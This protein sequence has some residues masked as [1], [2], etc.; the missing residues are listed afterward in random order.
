MKKSLLFFLIPMLFL[1]SC[2]KEK[3]TATAQEKLFE[4]S[5]L[6]QHFIVSFADDHGTILTS[7]YSGYTFILSKTDYYH[8]SMKAI[9]SGISYT[10]TWS[11]NNDYGKLIITLPDAKAELKFLSREWRFKS[12]SFSILKLAPWGEGD[13]IN[14]HMS[15]E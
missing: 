15:K 2:N 13:G 11:T 5:I 10:G 9:K 7:N 12:K 6:N 4:N 14:V 8:G 3:N 1:F